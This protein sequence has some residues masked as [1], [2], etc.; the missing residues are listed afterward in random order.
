MRVYAKPPG[1]PPST[2]EPII[3]PIGATVQSIQAMKAATA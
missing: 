3:L 2:K 1:K